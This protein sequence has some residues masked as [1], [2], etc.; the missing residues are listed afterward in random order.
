MT[1][2]T[3]S[4]LRSLLLSAAAGALLLLASPAAAD[5]IF[6]ALFPVQCVQPLLGAAGICVLNNGCTKTCFRNSRGVEA[7]PLSLNT[8]AL[9]GFYIPVDAV[10]CDELE[11]PICPSITCCRACEDELRALYR[12]LILEGNH[13]YL[14]YLATTCPID[15]QGFPLLPTL[16]VPTVPPFVDEEE[17]ELTER[18]D[19]GSASNSTLEDDS[20]YLPGDITTDGDDQII[21]SGE[22]PTTPEVV[23]EVPEAE[24]TPIETPEPEIPATIPPTA[25]SI[26][27]TAPDWVIPPVMGVAYQPM[28]VRAGDTLTFAWSVGTHDVFVYPNGGCD[29]TNK[30]Q[31]ASTRDNPTTVA[32]G[33][34]DVGKTITFACDIGSHCEAGM[35]MEVTVLTRGTAVVQTTPAT[36]M[37]AVAVE[38]SRINSGAVERVRPFATGFP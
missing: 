22:E 25:A 14:D 29:R 24:P 20:E 35:R 2:A 5:T 36:E 17:E 8:P 12:C 16:P 15:C 7:N 11:D 3:A 38:R 9:E 21:S 23:A 1:Q 18:I 34:A 27:Y 13:H 10:D 19:A 32:F 37:G 28:T 26:A 4:S 6:E 31:I 30:V 33:D